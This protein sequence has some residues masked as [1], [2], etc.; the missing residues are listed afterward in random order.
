MSRKAH[1]TPNPDPSSQKKSVL[2]AIRLSP[3]ERD[4]L[5]KAARASNMNFSLYC[6]EVLM[7]RSAKLGVRKRYGSGRSTGEEIAEKLEQN[8]RSFEQFRKYVIESPSFIPSEKYAPEAATT[9]LRMLKDIDRHMVSIRRNLGG[10]LKEIR[11]GTD[12]MKEESLW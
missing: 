3:E 12:S 8:L 10:L 4:T 7:K 1:N 11:K 9:S 5:R 2:I 6:R